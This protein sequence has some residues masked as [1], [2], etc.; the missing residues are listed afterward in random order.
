MSEQIKV[1]G[2]GTKRI[3][4]F[5][6]KRIVYAELAHWIIWE[7]RMLNLKKNYK[8]LDRKSANDFLKRVD[9]WFSEYQHKLPCEPLSLPEMDSEL[10]KL[11]IA[12]GAHYQQWG[13]GYKKSSEIQK[14]ISDCGGFI[15]FKEF[16]AMYY[17]QD[18]NP[19]EQTDEDILIRII[20]NDKTFPENTDA[21]WKSYR[22]ILKYILNDKDENYTNR[23]GYRVWQLKNMFSEYQAIIE[24]RWFPCDSLS[25]E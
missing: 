21:S 2:V 5:S 15:T 4:V 19:Y 8:E 3:T 10:E 7:I 11:A 24:G 22:A 9:Y 18:I 14:I 17:K 25:D 13:K 6:K 23:Y 12:L 1:L 20:V 16:V